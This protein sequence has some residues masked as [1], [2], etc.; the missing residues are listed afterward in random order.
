MQQVIVVNMTMVIALYFDQKIYFSTLRLWDQKH[1]FNFEISQLNHLFQFQ[2]SY[3]LQSKD[4]SGSFYCYFFIQIRFR[5]HSCVRCSH[6]LLVYC[7]I[8]SGNS[9]IFAIWFHFEVE[10]SKEI[11]QLALLIRVYGSTYRGWTIS[12]HR[13]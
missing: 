11:F 1:A 12:W 9:E 6:C 10:S 13:R 5:L 7:G 8:P 2:L 3:F 4:Q